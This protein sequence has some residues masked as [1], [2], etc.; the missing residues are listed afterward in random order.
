[1]VVGLHNMVSKLHTQ[2]CGVGSC[3]KFDLHLIDHQSINCVMRISFSL[4]SYIDANRLIERPGHGEMNSTFT[5]LGFV[6]LPLESD[7]LVFTVSIPRTWVY[8]IY[9]R[10]EV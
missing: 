1:M 6:E 2:L 10:Y 9:I 7:T 5:G 4:Q 8:Y 3:I